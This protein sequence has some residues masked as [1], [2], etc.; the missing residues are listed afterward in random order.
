M[1]S[2]EDVFGSEDVFSLMG[3]DGRSCSLE[4][5]GR[6]W[7]ISYGRGPSP[8]GEVLVPSSLMGDVPPRG[9]RSG[10]LRVWREGTVG[11]IVVNR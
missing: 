5:G 6:E 7:P 4:G 2:E 8:S 10:L 3:R 9:V 11:F 1:T